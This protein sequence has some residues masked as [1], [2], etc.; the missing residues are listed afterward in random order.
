M[1]GNEMV[2]PTSIL[3]VDEQR[4]VRE[5]IRCLLESHRD[6]QVVAEVGDGREAVRAAFEK[7]PDVVL[8][9]LQLPRLSGLEAI[10]YIRKENEATRCI[11][12]STH[13]SRSQV[14]EAL[15]AG[16]TGYVPKSSAS[17][18]LV[19]AIESVRSGRPY[20]AHTVAEHVVSAI[21]SAQ[22][23]FAAGDAADLTCREREVLQLIAEGLSTKEIAHE[24][25]I[26]VKTVQTHRANLMHKT[27]VHKA[28]SLVRYAI[29]E[30]LVSA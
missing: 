22:P 16:A 6:F 5:G 17:K 4:M 29:R 18:E 8:I 10:R 15:L 1:E 12:V 26:S 13:G 25:G 20:L 30:G 24:L 28:S 9:E 11:V 3:L 2:A 21:T 14:K 19:D 23:G 7:K 27:G